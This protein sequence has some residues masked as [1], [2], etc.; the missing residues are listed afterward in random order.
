LAQGNSGDDGDVT[1]DDDLAPSRVKPGLPPKI[2][3]PSEQAW[4]DA[5]QKGRD[6]MTTGF[7]S[8]SDSTTSIIEA[9]FRA[10]ES[11]LFTVPDSG[12]KWN[13]GQ[14]LGFLLHA[15]QLQLRQ[16]E[17]TENKAVPSANTVGQDSTLPED[18]SQNAMRFCSVFTGA[19]GTGK[20]ALLQ[21]QDMLTEAVYKKSTCVYRSA[22]T[23]TAAR[24]NR[25]N[26]CHAAWNLPFGS[27]L[28]PR[29]RISDTTLQKIQK[30]CW[31]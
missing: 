17:S 1:T 23:R 5:L 20:T 6:A 4:K 11:G 7:A 8:V 16:N 14:C 27:C 29:G 18:L 25:G 22:P 10:L 12:G 19:A 21:A 24:L 30:K 13:P 9:A 26:T 28:G 3:S 31:V 15:Y 2:L